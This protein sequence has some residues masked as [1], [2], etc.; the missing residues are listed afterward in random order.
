MK[1]LIGVSLALCISAWSFGQNDQIQNEKGQDLMPVA[2]EIGVGVNAIPVFNY[3]GDIFGLSSNNTSLDT[4]KFV[5]YFGQQSLFGKYMLT[6]DNAVRVNL[7]VGQ[8]NTTTS[9]SLIDDFAGHPDSMTNDLRQTRQSDINIGI[10]Y[11]FRR[12]KNR[13]RGIYGGELL[14]SRSKSRE[15]YTY[16]NAFGVTNPSPSTVDFTIGPPFIASPQA[17]RTRSIVNG[18][19]Q[20][21]GV[22]LFGGIE[23]YFAPKIC[24][25]T[26]FGWSLGGAWQGESVTTTEFWSPLALDPATSQPG[27]VDF[28]ESEG[29]TVSSFTMDTDNFNGAVYFLFWF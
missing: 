23:Y 11:E 18:T 29:F 8:F 5:G 13:L 24:V 21:L 17:T 16:G 28:Q 9:A 2:G 14:W 3:I 22:R 27:A 4:N 12:G 20:G 1:R 15:N 6:D 10:G 25:G 26:E 19:I 7:R